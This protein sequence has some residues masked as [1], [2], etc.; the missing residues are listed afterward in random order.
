MI[1]S[2][3]MEYFTSEKHYHTLN[4]YLADRFHTKVFKVSLNGNFTCPNR[5]GT[6]GR[7]G[8]LFCSEEGS[9]D[10]AGERSMSLTEQFHSILKM[11]K[12]KWPE[13]K[14][15]AYLQA[16]TNTYAPLEV[17]KQKYEEIINIDPNIVIF[18]IA[19]RPDCLSDEVIAYL[20][21][22]NKRIE[23]WVELGF[24]TVHEQ[25]S[26]F[27][28]RGYKNDVFIDAVRRLRAQS[29]TTIVHIINGLPGETKEMMIETATFLNSLD[30]QGIKIHMLHIMKNTPL[31]KVYETS[32]FK[33]LDLMEYVNILISQLEVLRPEIVIHRITGD[34]PKDLLIT[35]TWTLK[36][37]VVM[38]EIDKK[39]RKETIFQGDKICTR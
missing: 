10:Y 15:I 33:V 23:V 6:I 21:E 1:G 16:N 30:I 19:T 14:Y 37:F 12:E 28:N 32:P 5:D 26:K 39:M 29:I 17:L 34:A 18:S 36:K 24:Q 31:A 35:P 13:G 11:M 7:G 25:T 2:D 20:G 3:S 9:G 38:D 8:C 22:L 27:L 4:N